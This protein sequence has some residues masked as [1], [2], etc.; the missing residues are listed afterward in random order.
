M[1]TQGECSTA[2]VATVG[3]YHHPTPHGMREESIYL[4]QV[5]ESHVEEALWQEL[6]FD[7]G[8]WS[9]PGQGS[10]MMLSVLVSF[11]G[12]KSKVERETERANIVYPAHQV[13]GTNTQKDTFSLL[14]EM[15]LWEGW[16][17]SSVEVHSS[18]TLLGT[19]NLNII[20]K[21]TGRLSCKSRRHLNS[22]ALD[23]TE[24]G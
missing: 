6:W 21:A 22:S 11:P 4:R 7:G 8:V 13:M 14:I 3:D 24:V 10:L 1:R 9:R 18:W 16:Q 5:R 17:P 2:E 15:C 20:R 19:W 12:R 23:G